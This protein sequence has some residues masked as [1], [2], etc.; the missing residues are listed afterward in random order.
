[1]HILV[2]DDEFCALGFALRFFRYF[3]K[4]RDP[5]S[6]AEEGLHYLRDIHRIDGLK[7]QTELGEMVQ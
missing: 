2:M 6:F 4:L 1:M 3:Y 7:A 5:F